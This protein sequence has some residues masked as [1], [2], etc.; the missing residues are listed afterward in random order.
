MSDIYMHINQTADFCLNEFKARFKCLYLSQ[1]YYTGGADPSDHTLST[2][3]SDNSF[4]W[5]QNNTWLIHGTWVYMCVFHS[6]MLL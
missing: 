3:N 5:F 4:R 6:K 1:A 2:K